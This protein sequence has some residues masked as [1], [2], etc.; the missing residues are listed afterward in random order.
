[1]DPPFFSFPVRSGPLSI[2]LFFTESILFPTHISS[3]SSSRDVNSRDSLWFAVEEFPHSSSAP[4]R[5]ESREETACFF[6]RQDLLGNFLVF[7]VEMNHFWFV[8]AV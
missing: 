1:M 7:L 4:S 3:V 6:F 8:L 5:F 2:A